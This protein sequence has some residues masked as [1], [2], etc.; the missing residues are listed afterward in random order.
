MLRLREACG[1][2]TRSCAMLLQGTAATVLRLLRRVYDR[3]H[4][5]LRDRKEGLLCRLRNG[6]TC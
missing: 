4:M 2:Y 6:S 5:T 3:F 1:K